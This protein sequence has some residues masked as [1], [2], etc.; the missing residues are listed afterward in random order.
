[1][2]RK[3]LLSL[4]SRIGMGLYSLYGISGYLG[5]ILS[6]SRLVALGLGTGIIA[7]VVNKMA[8]VAGQAPVYISV[9]LVPFILLLGHTFNL[10]INILSA[11]VHTCRLQYVEFFTK[12]YES[13]GRFFKPF[14]EEYKYIKIEEK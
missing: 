13:G 5:D 1:M 9:I 10:A 14:K 12:F 4:L 7:M 2:S 8:L 11:F 6:Y 3:N